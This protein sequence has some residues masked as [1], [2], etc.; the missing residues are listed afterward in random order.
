M[1]GKPDQRPEAFAAFLPRIKQA[2]KAVVN[3]TTG[4]A[5]TM[6]EQERGR[7]AATFKP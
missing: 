7:P 6:T 1:S 5:P 2:S 4:G 3:I